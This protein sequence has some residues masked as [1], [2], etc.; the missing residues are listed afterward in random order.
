MKNMLATLFLMVVSQQLFANGGSMDGGGGNAGRIGVFPTV[1]Q[2]ETAIKDSKLNV[3]SYL[4]AWESNLHE[5][6]ADLKTL[7]EKVY[8]NKI[9]ALIY[10]TKFEN[11]EGPCKDENGQD[12]DA[13]IHASQ[14]GYICVSVGR[15]ATRL[16]VFDYDYQIT[17]LV[18]HEFSHLAGLNEAEAQR[19]QQRV[20]DNVV[21]VA[22]RYGKSVKS[23]IDI[24]A[25]N[26]RN[27]LARTR[28]ALKN[29]DYTCDIF[30]NAWIATPEWFMFYDRLIFPGGRMAVGPNGD[31]EKVVRIAIKSG[32]V[33]HFAKTKK[34]DTCYDP[35]MQGKIDH[36]F[37]S[38][39]SLPLR[40]A[41]LFWAKDEIRDWAK[42]IPSSAIVLKPT[43]KNVITEL[44]ELDKM[45]SELVEYYEK[46][47]A[48][49]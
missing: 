46:L 37:G 27:Y 16:N 43:L 23:D 3:L 17:A 12:V 34:G 49:Y 28:K 48:G 36:W 42:T 8:Q 19:F 1:Q 32:N 9:D 44:E 35:K 7:H 21:T 24:Y 29:D 31:R 30:K 20:L 6:P 10:N 18:A 38:Q 13:S 47:G 40:D 5:L 15:L 33:F 45:L 39:S 26:F 2:I 25:S 14:P 4:W 41:T 22:F 11:R